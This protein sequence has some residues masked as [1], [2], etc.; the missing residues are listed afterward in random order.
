MGARGNSRRSQERGE[1]WVAVQPASGVTQRRVTDHA[2][3]EEGMPP[4]DY[5][6][7]E[8]VF[9]HT[10]STDYLLP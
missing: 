2:A 7:K 1:V 5:I 4:H 9:Y 8:T 6:T 3:R 10:H